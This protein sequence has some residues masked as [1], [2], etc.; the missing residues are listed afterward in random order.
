MPAILIILLIIALIAIGPLLSIWA[1]NTLF[2][3][4]IPFTWK[5]WLAALIL[6][7]VVKGSSSSSSKK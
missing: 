7:G 3:L 4:A 5:T 6:G 1:L 2:A